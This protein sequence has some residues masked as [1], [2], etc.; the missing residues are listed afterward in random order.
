MLSRENGSTSHC[1]SGYLVSCFLS[2]GF[3]SGLFEAEDGGFGQPAVEP[4]RP[5]MTSSLNSFFI[6]KRSS[7]ALVARRRIP[8]AAVLLRHARN[9]MRHPKVY[10]QK[11]M[12]IT[13]NFCPQLEPCHLA[14]RPVGPRGMGHETSRAARVSLHPCAVFCGRHADFPRS[15]AVEP[16]ELAPRN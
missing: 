12:A 9:R 8:A 1:R 2:S 15:R 6:R 16:P 7:G 10:S 14:S 13:V 3:F 4:R 5:A 11:K